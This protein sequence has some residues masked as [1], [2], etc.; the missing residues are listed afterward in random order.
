MAGL[1]SVGVATASL[2]SCGGSA[3]RPG[4]TSATVPPGLTVTSVDLAHVPAT[5]DIAYV[6]KVMD[7]LDHV[8]GDA[9]RVFVANKGPNQQFIDLL[10]AV[11]AGPQYDHEVANYGRL[12]AEWQSGSTSPIRENPGDPVTRVESL[13]DSSR[14]CV[15]ALVDRSF[16][17]VFS[18]PPT[19]GTTSAVIQLAPLKHERDRGQHNATA[20]ELTGDGVRSQTSVPDQPCHA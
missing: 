17:A 12:A 7:A 16:A 8:L 3:H 11:Y 13:V 18:S 20:W 2:T 19:P 1:T 15:V 14:T 4:A 9:I 6:Q 5:I 10:S